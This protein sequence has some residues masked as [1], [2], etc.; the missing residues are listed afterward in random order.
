M[1]ARA[2]TIAQQESSYQS[3]DANVNAL[4]KGLRS[5]GGGGSV[6]DGGDVLGDI[7]GD[8]VVFS[9]ENKLGE[10]GFGPVY[11]GRLV[12]GTRIAIKRLSENSG[13][14]LKEFKAEVTLIT[15]LQ[16]S[17]L[18]KLLGCCLEA[19]ELLLV[20]DYMPNN[21]L[22]VHLFEHDLAMF[23]MLQYKAH[24]DNDKVQL[25]IISSKGVV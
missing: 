2:A 8:G 25:I 7:G 10:G 5:D 3:S 1:G 11:K 14:G 21:S 12:D 13:Q 24:R 6:S 17:N 19:K 15:K 16:H 9:V 4:N 23:M 22:D 18:V 20:Y